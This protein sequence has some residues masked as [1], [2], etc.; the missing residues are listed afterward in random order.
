MSQPNETLNR[1]R[2]LAGLTAAM[3]SS[4]VAKHA[5]AVDASLAYQSGARAKVMTGRQLEL[6]KQ[7]GEIIIPETDTPGAIAADVHGYI[8]YMLAEFMTE[9]ARDDFLAGLER[10]DAQAGGFLELSSDEQ[11]AFVE[12]MDTAA[13]SK[14]S[15]K[16]HSDYR[17]LKSWVTTGFFTS[18]AGMTEAG[19][20]RPLPGPMVEVTRQ[21]WLAYNGWEEV[22]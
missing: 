20:Y 18:E 12:Q 21:E 7:I 9:E 3:G 2:F 17:S 16:T 5:L 13:Y 1:R 6:V 10:I 22:R 15:K 4:F 11:S 14:D 19:I 8:D